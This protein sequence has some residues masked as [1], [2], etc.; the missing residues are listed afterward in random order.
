MNVGELI[1]RLNEYPTDMLVNIG[2]GT[3]CG[4]NRRNPKFKV[5][6]AFL[7]SWYQVLPFD[8]YGRREDDESL[9]EVLFL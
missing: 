9:G 5:R 3:S 7:S 6:E 1:E 4:G 2:D 8:L